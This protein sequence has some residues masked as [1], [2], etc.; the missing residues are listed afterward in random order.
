MLVARAVQE[1]RRTEIAALLDRAAQGHGGA[2]VITGGPGEGKSHA[3]RTAPTGWTVR[4]A[5]GHPDES[6]LPYAGL[7]RLLEGEGADAGL[8]QP[9]DG[10]GAGGGGPLR[11]ALAVRNRWRAARLPVL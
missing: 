5:P 2:L 7:E 8:R 1:V 9:L 3:V 11:V 4:S 6:T 10:D